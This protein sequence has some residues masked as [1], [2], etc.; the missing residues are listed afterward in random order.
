MILSQVSG[1]LR[2]GIRGI[3][4]GPDSAGFSELL[5]KILSLA[6]LYASSRS[7]LVILG[8]MS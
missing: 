5:P 3:E 4:P 6:I 1:C 8:D 2:V 7:S